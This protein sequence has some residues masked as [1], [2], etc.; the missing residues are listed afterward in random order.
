MQK[1]ICF[2][3]NTVEVVFDALSSNESLAR[4][5][6]SCFAASKNPT[7]EELSDLK[8]AISEAVTNVIVHAYDEEY[9]R[10]H[11]VGKVWMNLKMI[12]NMMSIEIRDEGVGISNVEEAMTPLFTTKTEDNRS[13]MGFSFMEAFMDDLS[14]ISK[15]DFGT[16]VKMKKEIGRKIWIC[17]EDE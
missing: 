2:V 15:P 10:E 1:Q 14:V 4:V 9:I 6:A 13:G 12:G 8:T 5:V 3:D 16:I 17:S 11:G 7:L